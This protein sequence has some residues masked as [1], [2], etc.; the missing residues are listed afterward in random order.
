[1]DCLVVL[2]DIRPA[3]RGV[4]PGASSDPLRPRVP[5]SVPPRP[6]LTQHYSVSHALLRTYLRCP[7]S[8]AHIPMSSRIPEHAPNAQGFKR[9]FDRALEE[10]TNKTGTNLALDPLAETLRGCSSTDAVI[11]VYEDKLH[12]FKYFRRPAGKKGKVIAALKPVVEVML[13]LSAGAGG[14]LGDALG[15]AF[16]P[17]KAVLGGIGVLLQAAKKVSTSY[18]ALVSL[19]ESISN[20]LERLKIYADGPH[21]LAPRMSTILVKITVQMLSIS[22][23]ATQ[24]IRQGRL[25]KFAKTLLGLDPEIDGAVTALDKLTAEEQRVV[26]ALTL[27][28]VQGLAAD[29]NKQRLREWLSPPDP[30]MNH[31]DTRRRHHE[32]T[33]TWLVNSKNFLEWKEQGS[34]LWISGKPGAGKTFLCST[35]IEDLRNLPA[36]SDVWKPTTAYFYCTFRDTEKQNIQGLLRSILHQLSARSDTYYAVLFHLFSEKHSGDP[37]LG[38][39]DTDLVKCLK[40]LLEYSDGIPTYIIVDALD[41]CPN[42][43]TTS[44]RQAILKLLEDLAG[45]KHPALRLCVTSRPEDDIGSTLRPLASQHV[46]LERSREQ[47]EDIIQYIRSMIESHGKMRAWPVKIKKR[48]IGT[49]SENANGMFRYASCQLD[50]LCDCDVTNIETTLAALPKT[51]QETYETTLERIEDGKWQSAHRLFQCLSFSTRP[52]QVEELAEVLAV[53]FRPDVPEYN[54]DWRGEDPEK[55]VLSVCPGSFVT[56][57]EGKVDQEDAK[58]VQFAHFSVKEFLVS[59]C[60]SAQGNLRVERFHVIPEPS[61]ATLARVCLGIL[62]LIGDQPREN[63][64]HPLA[65]YAARYW[66][67]HARFEDVSLSI[68]A[69]LQHFFQTPGPYLSAWTQLHD[70]HHTEIRFSFGYPE[71]Y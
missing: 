26:A 44:E 64:R 67:D 38:P 46:A 60:S 8:L 14:V 39:T 51:L 56:I 23:L 45:L 29:M 65:K 54:E 6:I 17:A 62:F 55:V 42:S 47:D 35:V 40:A 4:H 21:I 34:L 50:T 33:S 22:A 12:E 9:L 27:W 36:D 11:E 57:V 32:G 24:Q 3:P 19:F 15:S 63:S 2:Y 13:A 53:D 48:V 28:T 5:S 43:G 10:Y 69:S 1:M 25:K 16:P 61:H 41:E 59:Y 58:V 30:S 7:E 68:V 31:N 20:F 49:L 71:Y 37:K 70:P 52:L 66:V 18:D